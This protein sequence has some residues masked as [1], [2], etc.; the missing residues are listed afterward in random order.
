VRDSLEHFLLKAQM[1]NHLLAALI[2]LLTLNG[3]GQNQAGQEEKI[4]SE[5]N[6]DFQRNLDDCGDEVSAVTT[7]NEKTEFWKVCAL[8]NGNRIIQIESYKHDTHFQEL[9]FEKDGM[10]R[11]ARETENYIPTN[12]FIQMAWNSEFYAE[13]GAL[14]SLM[15]LGHGKTEDDAWNPEIIFEMHQNRLSELGRILKVK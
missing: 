2:L 12:H 4:R 7:F 9:Y 8:K 10:L 6:D 5:I 14:I 3:L 13:N 15:S 11:Y 1:K